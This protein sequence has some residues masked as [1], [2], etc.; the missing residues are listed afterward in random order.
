M[1]QPTQHSWLTRVFAGAE[2][3]QKESERAEAQARL[4]QQEKERAEARSFIS[5]ALIR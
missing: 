3:D 2:L 5:H 4:A 1:T